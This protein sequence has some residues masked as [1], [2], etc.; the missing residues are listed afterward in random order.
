[1]KDLRGW[2]ETC[3]KAGELKRIKAEVD[4]NLELSHIATF[5]EKKGGPASCLKILKVTIFQL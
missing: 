3:E 4:W 1:M 5:N 2:I